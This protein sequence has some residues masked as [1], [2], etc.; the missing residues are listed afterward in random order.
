MPVI[1]VVMGTSLS[2]SHEVVGR[3]RLPDGNRALVMQ[4][5]GYKDARIRVRNTGWPA[6]TRSHLAE[7][8]RKRQPWRQLRGNRIRRELHV[9]SRF[10]APCWVATGVLSRWLESLSRLGKEWP[11]SRVQRNLPIVV[12]GPKW[13][14]FGE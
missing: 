14:A 1:H 3:S 9:G 8:R 6:A 7:K 12:L 4:T 5:R 10:E 13:K 2:I 11:L